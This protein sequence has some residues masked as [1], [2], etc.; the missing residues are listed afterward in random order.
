MSQ[1]RVTVEGERFLINGRPTYEGRE[2]LGSRIEGLLMNSRMVQATFDDENPQTR[3]LWAYPDTGEWDPERNVGEFL[4]AMPEWR[5][6]GL[7]AVTLCLQGGC[8][9]GYCQEQPWINTALAPDGS[10]KSLYCE[11]LKRIFEQADALGMV[12]ILGIYYFGQDEHIQNESAVLAGAD[13]TARWILAEDYTNVLIEVA[14]ECDIP[15]YDHEVLQPSRIHEVIER[16]QNVHHDGRRLLV[17]TSYKGGAIPSERVVASSDVVFLHGNGVND[18][19]Q[20][21]QMVERVR[22]LATYQSMPIVFNEDD[23]F[24]FNEPHNNMAAALHSYASWGYYD[25]GPGS[26]GHHAV[27]DYIEGYQNVPVNW[28]INTSVKRAFFDKVREVT[29]V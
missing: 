12:V 3:H 18:P 9:Q 23:H 15:R 29:G 22:T 7:L 25:G 5:A 13:N 1:T 4:A 11:R 16:V 8:P 6:H 24:V 10:L 17:G 27:G 21:T 28:G 20:I 19:T 14:N 2:Y 26:G